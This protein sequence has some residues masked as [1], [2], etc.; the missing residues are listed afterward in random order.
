[1]WLT[2]VV[3]LSQVPAPAR[4]LYRRSLTFAVVFGVFVFVAGFWSGFRFGSRSIEFHF[5]D[6]EPLF[7]GL[8]IPVI[9]LLVWVPLRWW[10]TSGRLAV[11]YARRRRDG[12]RVATLLGHVR[13]KWIVVGRQSGDLTLTSEPSPT[14]RDKD[15]AQI[16][17]MWI[18][19]DGTTSLRC[20]VDAPVGQE[21]REQ[22]ASWQQAVR[23]SS[24]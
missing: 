12:W 13:R 3:R 17:H 4:G 10:T 5:V 15:G 16:G 2:P 22:L 21:Q 24:A 23:V 9:V 8:A 20:D 14:R 1:M 19:S 11:L 6:P 18:L 7:T